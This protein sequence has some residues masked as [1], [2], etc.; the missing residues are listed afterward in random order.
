M[1][2]VN[3]SDFHT[4]YLDHIDRVYR[5]VFFRVGH[6]KQVAE[7]LTSEIF[8]KALKAYQKY[9]PKV[10]K[11]AWITT[12]ARNHLANWYRDSKQH[13]DI[14]EIAF[15]L[16][17]S[18][19]ETDMEEKSDA[20]VL[21]KALAKLKP[22]E[23]NLIELKHLQGYRFKEIGELLGKTAGAARVEC[24]RAMEKLRKIMLEPK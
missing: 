23:R 10:S 15:K 18:N 22:K 6:N 5:F 1:Q 19:L 7:D 12:I 17:G 20:D 14:D 2:Q 9:D 24:H 16:E 13:D 3:K 4:F 21:H 8:M 11:N